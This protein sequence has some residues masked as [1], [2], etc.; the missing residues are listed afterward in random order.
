MEIVNKILRIFFLKGKVVLID[1]MIYLFIYCTTETL[2]TFTHQRWQSQ[3][4][5][6]RNVKDPALYLSMPLYPGSVNTA[7]TALTVIDAMIAMSDIVKNFTK[8]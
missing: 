7:S 5:D 3:S 8:Q 1:A 6:Q 4:Q 2:N